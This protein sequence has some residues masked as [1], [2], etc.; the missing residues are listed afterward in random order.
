MVAKTTCAKKDKKGQEIEEGAA[1][2]RTIVPKRRI[3]HPH[4]NNNSY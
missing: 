2:A 1:H 3:N 4:N